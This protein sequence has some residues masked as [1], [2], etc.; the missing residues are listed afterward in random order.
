MRGTPLWVLTV[1]WLRHGQFFFAMT[2]GCSGLNGRADAIERGLRADDLAPKADCFGFRPEGQRDELREVHNRQF[3]VRAEV[4]IDFGLI[5]IEVE[6]AHR[7][8]GGDDIRAAIDGGLQNLAQQLLRHIRRDLR[9]VPTATPR[10]RRKIRHF[11]AKVLKQ[12]VQLGGIFGLVQFIF[13]VRT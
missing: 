5:R 9:H 4:P 13:V 8:S 6:L 12:I 10:F 11:C 2:H 1:Q 3:E 7:A